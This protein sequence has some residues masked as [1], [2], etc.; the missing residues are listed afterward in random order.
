MVLERARGVRESIV[1][2]A[3]GEYDPPDSSKLSH[4]FA[5][6]ERE[7]PLVYRLSNAGAAAGQA[8]LAVVVSTRAGG[9]VTSGAGALA[10]LLGLG[11][12]GSAWSAR[13][14]RR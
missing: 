7:R 4:R 2:A 14:P 11:A 9:D 3:R 8:G 5:R 10:A 12:L 13:P 1:A 6:W